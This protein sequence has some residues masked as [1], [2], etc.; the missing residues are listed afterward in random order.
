MGITEQKPIVDIQKIMRMEA[1]HN[2]KERYQ[3]AKEESKKRRNK[4][5]LENN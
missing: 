5:K 3:T 1:K 4:E 2:S